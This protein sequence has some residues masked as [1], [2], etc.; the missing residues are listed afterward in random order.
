[1]LKIISRLAKPT[2]AALVW[3]TL[4]A[5]VLPASASASGFA[6]AVYQFTDPNQAIYFE[7]RGWGHGVGLCQWG[8][9]GRALAGQSAEQ[10]VTAYY[11]GA[12]IQKT[13]AP[14]TTMR[15]LV[16]SQYAPEPA[17]TGHV[18]GKGGRWQMEG[19]G[20]PAIQAPAG[21][22]LELSSQDGAPRFQV[23]D[24]A[25]AVL[26]SGALRAPLVLRPLDG[27]TRFV[28]GYKPAPAAPGKPG[29]FQ[30]VYRGEVIIAPRPNGVETV[31]R[32]SLEDY[33][34]GVVPAEM[35]ASWPSE[36]LK[37]QTLA[38][39]SYAIFQARTRSSERYDVDDTTAYQVY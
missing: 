11:T 2:R 18:T 31:N 14:E 10:I 25:G 16:H 32:L 34:R 8:A 27:N 20:V 7:G 26:G 6:A 28:V 9:R 15:V 29:E 1:M 13:I 23:K 30:D 35:P 37:A 33:L 21:A 39:R 36:A 22:Y 24:T 4:L 3:A 38:A 12:T 5:A 17:E 19:S